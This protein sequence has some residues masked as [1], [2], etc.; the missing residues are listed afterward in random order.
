MQASSRGTLRRWWDRRVLPTLID[1]A[2]KSHAI[3]EER[4]RWVP[5]ASGDILELG[6]GTGH[7]FR[8]YDAA[9]AVHVTAVDISPD[10]LAKAVPHA[11]TAAVPIELLQVDAQTLPFDQHRFDTVVSTYTMCSIDNIELALSEVRRVLKPSGRLIFVEHGLAARPS[12]ARWQKRLTP[13]W[14]TISGDCRLDRNIAALLTANNFALSELTT[15]TTEGPS[16][17]A[18]IYQGIARPG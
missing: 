4:M 11:R 1:K 13:A 3:L 6:A 14:R 9:H 2:C 17:A 16:I 12:T 8:F 10:V 15:G 5:Q 18:Y 7:N